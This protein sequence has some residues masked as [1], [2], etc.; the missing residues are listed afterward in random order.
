M[1]KVFALGLLI[2]ATTVSAFAFDGVQQDSKKRPDPAERMNKIVKELNLNE[3]QTKDF[4]KVNEEFVEKM[5]KER[6]ANK[7]DKGK[8]REAMAAAQKDRN[9]KI[10]KI[11]TEEQYKKFE[12]MEKASREQR[13]GNKSGNRSGNKSENGERGDRPQR[14]QRTQSN[15]K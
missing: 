4:K 14:A 15:M 9:A 12:E 10:K 6:E 13:N 5:K 7:E 11:L 3:K 1:K 2:L 8:A